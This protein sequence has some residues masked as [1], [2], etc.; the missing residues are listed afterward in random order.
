M[1]RN[2]RMRGRVRPGNGHLY[3]CGLFAWA[4]NCQADGGFYRVRATSQAPYLPIGLHAHT[5]GM[6]IQFTDPLDPASA[7]TTTNY[8]VKVWSLKRSANY[9]SPHL[10]EHPLSVTQA[11]LA[12]D[13]KSVFL[14]VPDLQPTWSMEIQCRLRGANGRSFTRTVHNTIHRLGAT[15]GD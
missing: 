15:R 1:I 10:N 3:T 12:A 2:P 9:G 7:N 8:A 13:R 14:T 4:G 6:E 11:T 5:N